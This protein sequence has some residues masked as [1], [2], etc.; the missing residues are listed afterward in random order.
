MDDYA[1]P[2]G[3]P[4]PKAPEVPAGWVARWNE[5]YKEWFYVN[6]YT[7]K[8]QWEKPTAPVFPVGEN[9]P[10]DPPPGYEPGNGPAPTDTKKNPYEDRSGQDQ[11]AGSSS[12]QDEDAKLAAKL[13]AEEHAR[14][15]G[16]P[17]PPAGYAS[18]GAADSSAQGHTGQSHT[19]FPTALPPRDDARGKDRGIL[20]KLFGKGKSPQSG[21]A[22]FAGGYPQHSNYQSSLPQQHVGY[23]Q[24][25]PPMGAYGGG[26]GQPGYGGYPPQP[27]YS[28]YGGGYPQGGYYQQQQQPGRRPG[29]GMGGM[30][31][32]LA[33]GALGLG[34]GVLGGALLAD[35]IHDHDQ[36]EYNQGYQDGMDNDYGGG[37]DF[38][39]GGD[40]GGGDF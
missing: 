39:G 38:D 21:Q 15:H 16:G 10:D 27:G 22:N 40:F 3:P 24:Q 13:Q 4:P 14:A 17:T 9:M 31:M 32:G 33:G 12:T 34:A 20:G 25:G 18:G 7:K 35:A 2:S 36:A 19:S 8:S 11:N 28:A 23:S 5:Q 29:G 6:V 30:G 37:G 1:P 26:Y